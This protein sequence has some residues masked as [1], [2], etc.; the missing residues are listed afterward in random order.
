MGSPEISNAWFSCADPEGE[1]I[2]MVQEDMYHES[3]AR[4]LDPDGEGWSG[5]YDQGDDDDANAY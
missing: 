3:V 5:Y 2:L 1:W 4:S